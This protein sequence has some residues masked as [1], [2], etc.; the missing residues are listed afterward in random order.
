MSQST[1]SPMTETY[2]DS[3]GSSSRPDFALIYEEHYDLLVGMARGKFGV[4]EMDAQTLAHE[5]FLDY[6]TK[7]DTIVNCRAWLVGAIC[8][9]SRYH[10]RCQERTEAL[11][12]DGTETADPR[13]VRVSDLWTD[14]LA[15]RQAFACLTPR[16]QLALRLRYLEGYSV[17]EIADSLATSKKYAQK[18]VTNCL[19]QAQR[20]YTRR[21][22]S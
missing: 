20:R 4:N 1:S 2:F 8:N 3:G 7:S 14:Q 9:A 15:A 17:P 18:L 10:L 19:K 13:S 16:C 11:P 21:D 22:R 5:V 6:F 12:P